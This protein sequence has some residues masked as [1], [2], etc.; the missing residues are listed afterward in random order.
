ME[1][2]ITD[3]EHMDYIKEQFKKVTEKLAD[4]L[5]EL[6]DAKARVNQIDAESKKLTHMQSIALETLRLAKM[7]FTAL[8][9]R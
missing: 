9:R 3:F 7:R 6:G 5:I 8:E 1:P 4:K 2:S